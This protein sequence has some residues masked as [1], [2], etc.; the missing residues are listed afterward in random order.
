MD[1]HNNYNNQLYSHSEPQT[2]HELESYLKK[3]KRRI[4][5]TDRPIANNTRVIKRSPTSI[6]I[7][8]HNTDVITLFENGSIQ[9]NTDGWKTVTT[10]DRMT[11]FLS[12]GISIYSERFIWYVRLDKKVYL[13]EDY[14]IITHDRFVTDANGKA[15]KEHSKSIE[16]K[17]RNQL[18]KIDKY[19]K[20]FL[21][22]LNDGNIDAPSAG[23]CWIC[24]AFNGQPIA[25]KMFDGKLVDGKL[26]TTPFKENPHCNCIQSHIDE[27]YFVPTLLWNA[28]KSECY[29]PDGIFGNPDMTYGLSQ[30]DK[31]NIS[32]WFNPDSEH[33]P[34]SS[35][36][37]IRR[38]QKIMK[39]FITKQLNF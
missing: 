32:C 24:Q 23:D 4:N 18:K 21:K 11:R 33:K 10:K 30:F 39:Q 20:T 15:I 16:K 5:T 29:D 14:M 19:I 34:F 22:E 26:E 8:L 3:G 28:I 7:K 12:A 38:L 13:Y 27:K 36:M 31:H 37:T 6:A 17:K 35:D 1:K 9:L 25:D 2:Y